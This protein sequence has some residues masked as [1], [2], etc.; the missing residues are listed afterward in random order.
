MNVSYFD[1]QQYINWLNQITHKNYRLPSET[2]WEYAARSGSDNAYS[3]GNYIGINHVNC[4]D[5]ENKG[6]SNAVKKFP[7]NRFGLYDMHGNVWEWVEDCWHSNY[8][9]APSDNESWEPI[10]C[11]IFVTRSGSS[12]SPAEDLRAAKR[13]N[14]N[15]DKRINSLGFRVALKL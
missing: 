4:R 2:E 5:C 14:M 10:A 8:S 1:A 11:N 7:A 3:W 6:A 13:G 9:G 15:A 12:S